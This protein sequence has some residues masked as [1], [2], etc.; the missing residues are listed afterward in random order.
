MTAPQQTA[1]LAAVLADDA[2]LNVLGGRDTLRPDTAAGDEL[3]ALLAA[4]RREV[5][6][7]PVGVLVDTPTAVHVITANQPA[8][9]PSRWARLTH[10][11]TRRTR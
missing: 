3:S 4:W 7:R 11:L 5:D 8:R 2:L 10:F 9:R 6:A 1:D